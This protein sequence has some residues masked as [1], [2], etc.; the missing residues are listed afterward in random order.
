M[1]YYARTILVTGPPDE[2][3]AASAAHRE[4]LRALQAAGK[5]RV[6][7]EFKNGDGFLEVLD[8]VDLHEAEALARESPLVEAGL[9][10][11]MIREWIELEF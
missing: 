5:L 7:G 4:H 9:G 10:A 8:V 2:V 11:W 3:E 1:P 6:A